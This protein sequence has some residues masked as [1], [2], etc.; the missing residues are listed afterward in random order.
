MLKGVK[1]QWMISIHVDARSVDDRQ[2]VFFYYQAESAQS[3]NKALEI[4]TIFADKYSKYR[5]R[6]YTGTVSARPLYVLRASLAE[7]IFIEL[8]NIHN[9]NDRKR[10]L[11]PRN[12]QLIADWITQ[13]FMP[14]DVLE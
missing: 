7:P 10:I 1:N 11:Y 2:D 9:E 13:G 3:K 8:A 12:R 5:D 4:R 6:A 14:K